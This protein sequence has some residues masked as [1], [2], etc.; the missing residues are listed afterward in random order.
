MNRMIEWVNFLLLAFFSLCYGY[1]LIYLLVGMV[2]RKP[3]ETKTIHMHR[4]AILIPARNEGAVIEGILSSIECQDYPSDLIDVY[5]IADNCTDDTGIRARER[6]AQVIVRNNCS[7]IGKGY[8][9]DYAL[10]RIE[11]KMGLEYYDAYMVFDADNVLDKGYVTAMNRTFCQGYNIITSYRNSKNYGENWITAGYSLWFMRESR[12]LN[13]ARMKLN[14]S[15]AISGTGFLVASQIIRED[16]GW[17]YNL[18]TE[19]IEFTTDHIIRGDKIGYC[20]DAVLYDE[21]PSTF[22]D[23]WN[24]RL[25]WTKGF[26]QVFAHYGKGLVRGMVREHRFQCYDMLMVI[27]PATLIT[28][29]SL[30]FNTSCV[31]AGMIAHSFSM[32]ESALFGVGGC[33]FSIYF[34]LL[35][36]G[37]CTLVSERKQI[38][39]S[40]VRQVLYLLMF[41]VFI[42]TYIPMAVAALFQKVTWKNIPHSIL[43]TP[44]QICG[45][46]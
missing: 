5:V 8:A 2:K 40:K 10:K 28:L 42:F 46:E 29:A 12:F 7:Q 21:Q 11:R 15:C 17:K 27:A 22:R 26:Y 19:D 36:F 18:L 31:A 41:P 9:L 30:I 44:D 13:G 38:H 32:V 43:C 39:C 3:K 20:Q 37:L 16:G 45:K 1:Q 25:R 35:F 33:L 6:G 4:F 24:Q 23:S 14:T 34:T